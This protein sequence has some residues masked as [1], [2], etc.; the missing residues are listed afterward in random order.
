MS[1]KEYVY[2]PILLIFIN[3]NFDFLEVGIYMNIYTR[4][5]NISDI[6]RVA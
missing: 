6:L 2:T 4:N 3:F 1:V 5:M